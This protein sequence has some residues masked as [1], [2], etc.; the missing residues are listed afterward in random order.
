MDGRN[1]LPLLTGEEPEWWR[2]CLMIEDVE[3]GWYSLRTTTHWYTEWD[4]GETELYDLVADPDQMESIHDSAP[5]SLMT[6]LSA[7]LATFKFCSAQSCRRADGG[8]D[9]V[10]PW[11]AIT[12]R[13]LALGACENAHIRRTSEKTPSPTLVNKGKREGLGTPATRTR[14]AR[15]STGS[16]TFPRRKARDRRV[17]MGPRRPGCR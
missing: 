17:V 8:L 15:T 5:D 3:R 6:E 12:G 1:L 9:T 7:T 14:C 4:T 2:R 13:F 16:P 10:M 11:N